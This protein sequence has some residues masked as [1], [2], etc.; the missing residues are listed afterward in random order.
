[1]IG[2]PGARQPSPFQARVAHVDDQNHCGS[3]ALPE[4]SLAIKRA[5]IAF[6][7]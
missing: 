4:L 3:Y 7:T 2:Q 5:R 1:L 6:S